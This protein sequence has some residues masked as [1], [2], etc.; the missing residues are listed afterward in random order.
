[1]FVVGKRAGQPPVV[2]SAAGLNK[3][4]LFLRDKLSRRKFLVDTG[5]EVSVLPATG[6]DKRTRP[7]GPCLIAANGSSIKTYGTNTL[8][9]CF[10]SKTYQWTFTIAEVS[11]PL[12]GADFLRSNALLVDL[13]RKRLV[14]AESY[15]S[16]SLGTTNTAVV[17]LGA[18]STSSNKYDSLLS[19]FPN[20][21]TPVL[22]PSSIKHKVEHFIPTTGPPVHAP[23]NCRSIFSM[24]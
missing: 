7:L 3:G 11:R 21:K 23:Y 4:L 13:Q 19:E 2:A 15:H 22:T 10:A 24:A 20:I 18:I 16:V 9:I 17:Q 6:L 1:M 12:L 5:A 14:D 8:S